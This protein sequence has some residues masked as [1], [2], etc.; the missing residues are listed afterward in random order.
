MH[1]ANYYYQV[2]LSNSLNRIIDLLE[3]EDDE[4]ENDEDELN[5]EIESENEW[6]VSNKSQIVI[7][8]SLSEDNV[9]L[10]TRKSLGA[11]IPAMRASLSRHLKQISV[12][13][14]NVN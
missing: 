8:E 11:E 2:N 14:K 1:N 5:E 7:D 12:V 9:N 10:I 3:F 4:I 6:L 13:A